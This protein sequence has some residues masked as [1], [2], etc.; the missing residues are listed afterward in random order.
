MEF[1]PNP[2]QEEGF[3]HRTRTVDYIVILEGVL[4]L[5]LDGGQKR[6]VK[7]GDVIVQRAPMHKWKNMSR[8]ESARFVGILLGADGAVEDGVEFGGAHLG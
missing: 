4:E 5:S 2:E 7:K 8:T 1:G 6:E 3:W